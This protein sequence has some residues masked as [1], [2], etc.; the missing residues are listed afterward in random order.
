[1]CAHVLDLNKND[2]SIETCYA[3][4][5]KKEIFQLDDL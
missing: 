1:M 2:C 4:Q 3:Q 5:F